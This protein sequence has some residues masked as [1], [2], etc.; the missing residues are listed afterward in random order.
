MAR[1]TLQIAVASAV[2]CFNDEGS[3]ILKVFEPGHFT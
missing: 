1:K 3:G 2:L